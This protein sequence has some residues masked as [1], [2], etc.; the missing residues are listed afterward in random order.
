L[1]RAHWHYVFQE[2][3]NILADFGA[4]N[5][6]SLVVAPSVIEKGHSPHPNAL[7]LR[8][9]LKPGVE[10]SARLHTA[11]CARRA[12][13]LYHVHWRDGSAHCVLSAADARALLTRGWAEAFPLAGVRG[14]FPG[15]PPTYVTVYAPRNAAELRVHAAIMRAAAAYAMGGTE[16]EHA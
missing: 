11:M 10:N 6:S 14:T 16:Q 2:L 9:D 1:L 4:A 3:Y 8:A 7:L 5:A 12:R 15:F 13:E